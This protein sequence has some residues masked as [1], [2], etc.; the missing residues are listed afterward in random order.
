MTVATFDF[1]AF[2]A[3]YPELCVPV[4]K[5]DATIGPLL[6]SQAGLYLDNTDCSPVCDVTART[7]LLYLVTAHLA[8]IG[9]GTAAAGSAAAQG[10]VGRITG[11]SE[12]SV[13]V[14]LDYGTQSASAA[15]WLQSAYGAAYWQASAPY[16]LGRYVP[17]NRGPLGPPDDFQ[18]RSLYGYGRARSG[19]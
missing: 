1:A 13:S 17:P 18:F 15:Y 8:A 19:W 14:S 6:F 10:L 11:A 12:G 4:G 3:L 5:V 9:P 7:M 16:R 2:S